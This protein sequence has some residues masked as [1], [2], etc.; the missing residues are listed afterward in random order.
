MRQPLTP[1][2][3]GITIS[4]LL[5][6]IPPFFIQ[7]TL[8]SQLDTTI[9]TTELPPKARVRLAQPGPDST[10]TL[11]STQGGAHHLT[12]T[13][14]R[15]PDLH[16]LRQVVVA[17]GS[18]PRNPS[19]LTGELIAWDEEGPDG[20]HVF[21][22]HIS[23]RGPPRVIEVGR[24]ER[25]ELFK[26]ELGIFLA[27]ETVE[28]GRGWLVVGRI[29]EHPP[30]EAYGRLEDA[31]EPTVFSDKGTL[32]LLYVK[33]R[34]SPSIQLARYVDGGWQL[35]ETMAALGPTRALGRPYAFQQQGG[36]IRVAWVNSTTGGRELLVLTRSLP[37]GRPE[38]V[39]LAVL[40]ADI[41]LSI[42]FTHGTA[43]PKTYFV[44]IRPLGALHTLNSSPTFN[45]IYGRW[46]AYPL[47]LSPRSHVLEAPGPG[48]VK[49]A[50]WSEGVVTE[51]TPLPSKDGARL[52]WISTSPQHTR[53][54]VATTYR[55]L[56]L[57]PDPL[58]ALRRLALTS[59]LSPFYGFLA[60]PA[61]AL[62]LGAA[63]LI[64]R[65][66]PGLGLRRWAALTLMVKLAS[67]LLPGSA[68]YPRAL[69]SVATL[70]L[71]HITLSTWRRPHPGLGASASL[72]LLDYIYT[73]FAVS[74]L[75]IEPPF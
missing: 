34:P 33:R 56:F 10:I 6:I 11:L 53:L 47:H 18:E 72:L 57:P 75:L 50:G 74:P 7:E 5:A 67:L 26:T 61:L 19:I 25:P 13:V 48:E 3:R 41:P 9:T 52:A 2:L 40:E 58:G 62:Q 1:A 32:Y 60:M 28:E 39:R 30:V 46:E 31:A 12:L 65:L 71:A 68:I 59:L 24:G 44:D 37:T 42:T 64:S 70:G 51:L 49:L 54:Q 4:L 63:G 16:P 27:Y 14:Y 69:L 66:K 20:P 35:V 36:A 45:L 43:P 8:Q 17:R 38:V 21:F 23:P 29:G 55:P 22:A 73:L 15:I